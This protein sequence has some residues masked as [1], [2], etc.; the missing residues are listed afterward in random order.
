MTRTD[1][2]REREPEILKIDIDGVE[3]QYLHYPGDGPVLLLLHATG[4]LPWL[5]HPIARRLGTDYRIIAPYFCGHRDNDPGQGGVSWMV[6]ARDIA[7]LCEKLSVTPA[8]LAGHSMGATVITIAH[9]ELGLPAERIILIEP[10]FL[11][12]FLYT[13]GMTVEQ[14]PLAARSLKRRNSWENRDEAREYLKSKSMFARW[15]EEMLDLYLSYGMV[16]GSGGGLELTCN[17]RHEASLFMGGLHFNPWPI[18]ASIQCPVL[19]VEGE[20]SENRKFIDLQKIKSLLPKGEY[21]LVNNSG[22]LV[23]QE[24]P[25]EVAAIFMDF[26]R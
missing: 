1:T 25:D 3:I 26:F 10:I 18:L 8:Y 2:M 21:R 24:Q 6:L 14:H 13:T 4:L 19:L 16:P 7:A 23:P 5:W 12:E 17:P 15:D 11:P 22:H 20:T 9:A